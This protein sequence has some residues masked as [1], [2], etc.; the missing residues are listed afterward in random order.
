MNGWHQLAWVQVMGGF[1]AANAALLDSPIDGLSATDPHL[2]QVA[3]M[4][5]LITGNTQRNAAGASYSDSI[6]AFALEEALMLPQGTWALPAINAMNP[7]FEVSMFAFPGFNRG[8]ELTI[9]AADLAFSISS[10]VSEANQEAAHR[11]LEFLTRP[12]IMQRYFDEDGSP[13]SVMAVQTE[14][15]FEEMRPVTDLAFTDKQG[16][17]LHAEWLSEPEFHSLTV[18][19]MNNSDL[20]AF[21]NDMN[22]FFNMHK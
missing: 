10:D 12:E 16:I 20:N 21:V 19:F 2:L 11:F 18:D 22:R 3:D 13:T 6:S 7:E 15:R 17:W 5:S 9:G 4:L 14:G 1:E 8:D